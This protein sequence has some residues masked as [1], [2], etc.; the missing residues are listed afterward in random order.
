MK[1]LYSSNKETT[2][3]DGIEMPEE[4]IKLTSTELK[5]QANTAIIDLSNTTNPDFIAKKHGFKDAKHLT[6]LCFNYILK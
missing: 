5:K 4:W 3:I 6:D 2:I 1:T